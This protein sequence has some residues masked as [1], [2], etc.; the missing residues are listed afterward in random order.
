LGGGY[1][2]PR[3]SHSE[4]LAWCLYEIGFKPFA[5]LDGS[6]EF[7]KARSS[8]ARLKASAESLPMPNALVTPAISKISLAAF[9]PRF[10]TSDLCPQSIFYLELIK[11]HKKQTDTIIKPKKYS[12]AY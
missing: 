1:W 12:T 10:R 7:H 6:H 5:L 11:D 2:Q 8:L 9:N 3:P 4:K